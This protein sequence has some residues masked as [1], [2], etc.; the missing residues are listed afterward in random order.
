MAENDIRAHF[1]YADSDGNGRIDKDEFMRLIV[2][3]GLKRPDG[4][5]DLAFAS[6][7]T[8]ENGTIDFPEFRAWLE[9]TSAAEASS[10]DELPPHAH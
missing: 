8:D 6:I 3:L 9:K 5:V 10:G 1:D 2:R 4:V 7:D